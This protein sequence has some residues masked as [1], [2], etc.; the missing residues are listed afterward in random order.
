MEVTVANSSPEKQNPSHLV[1]S[2]V[3]NVLLPVLIL[4]KLGKYIP[5]LSPWVIL[6]I[7]LCF[8]ISGAIIEWRRQKKASPISALGALNV[9]GTGGLAALGLGGIWFAVKEAFFPLLIAVGVLWTAFGRK[10]FAE[11]IF[12]NPTLFRVDRI[13]ETLALRSAEPHF[14][15]SLRHAT[16]AL[17]AS[18]MLSAGLNF[19]LALF[20]FEPIHPTLGEAQTQILNEQV[21]KMT[22]LSFLVIA[23]PSTL[24]TG[25]IF[26]NL[27]RKIRSLTG[28]SDTELF[29]SDT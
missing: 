20:V 8:P 15:R 11:T 2:L 22:W 23:L 29:V 21:A 24:C 19:G 12:V 28:L 18:F 16:M 25:A 27:L 9:I 6:C 26:W 1:S 17:A 7:A 4:N 3:L 13:R 14:Q 5:S 10:P